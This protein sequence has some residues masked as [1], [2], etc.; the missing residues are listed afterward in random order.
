MGRVTTPKYRVVVVADGAYLT[1]FTWNREYGR[2]NEAN[3]ERFVAT[4]NA[5]FEPGEINYH[6][7][8]PQ[9]VIHKATLVRQADDEVIATY[10]DLPSESWLARN[11]G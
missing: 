7:G 2:A 5:S 4:Y 9:V 10:E 1:P 8:S 3:L 6:E 11:P